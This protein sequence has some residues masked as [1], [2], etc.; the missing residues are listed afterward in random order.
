MTDRHLRVL[1]VSDTES[2]FLWDYFDRT[3]LEGVELIISC[4]DVRADYLSF[5][6]TMLPVPCLYVPGNH[7]A[8]YLLHPP[9]G[10]ED[11]TLGP[12]TI[13]GIRFVGFGGC[14]SGA[15]K[16]YHYTEEIMQRLVRRAI[17]KFMFT[18]F[19]VLVTHCPAYGL[20]DGSDPF[21]EGFH[22][23][24]SLID[25]YKP[26]Y[27][28]HGHQHPS[29]NSRQPR[30]LIYGET[31]VINGYNYRILDLTIPAKNEQDKKQT[32]KGLKPRG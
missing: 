12:K 10:C 21:H 25:R 30:D 28:F 31:T 9:E 27:H 26:A 20:G 7:D 32:K 24:R 17:P 3:C 22:V 4:G 6:V 8:S 19:D 16:P 11:L 29:Y 2:K 13:K 1:V 18:G 23:Y 5:L 14:K 15:P